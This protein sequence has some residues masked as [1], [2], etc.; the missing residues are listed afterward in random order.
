MLITCLIVAS[1]SFLIALIAI[2]RVIVIQRSVNNLNWEDVANLTGDIATVKKTIQ[3]LNN[4]INGMH[5]PRLADEQL[6]QNF[7]QQQP[8]NLNGK[9]IGG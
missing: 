2:T 8:K 4:R 1:V 9:G 5:S 3:T 7:L 6:I